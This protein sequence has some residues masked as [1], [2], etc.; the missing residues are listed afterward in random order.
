MLY[1]LLFAVEEGQRQT[2]AIVLSADEEPPKWIRIHL[3]RTPK[4]VTACYNFTAQ[5]PTAFESLLVAGWLRLNREPRAR[6]WAEVIIQLIAIHV[7]C[8]EIH[9]V[10]SDF[11]RGQWKK[12]DIYRKMLQAE[13]QDIQRGYF[14]S[15]RDFGY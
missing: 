13:D 3:D 14:V 1:T 15:I 5:N 11:E 2:T 10:D 9:A 7:G 12:V 6:K 8:E 4:Q